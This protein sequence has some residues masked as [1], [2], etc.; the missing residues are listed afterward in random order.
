LRGGGTTSGGRGGKE[1]VSTKAT[2]PRWKVNDALSGVRGGQ[3]SANLPGHTPDD[4][5]VVEWEQHIQF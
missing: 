4:N 5:N 3:E 2:T 1:E